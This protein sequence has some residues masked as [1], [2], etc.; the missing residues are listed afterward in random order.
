[1][2][3]IDAIL[4]RRSI[5]RFTEEPVTEEQ[6]ETI[7]RA[8]MYAPSAHNTRT[9]RFLSITDKEKLEELSG[10]ARYWRPLHRATAAI[11][12]LADTTD[13]TPEREEFLIDNSVAATQNMLL[14]AHALG[15]GAVWLNLCQVRD[16]YAPVMECLK[17]PEHIR[18][19]AMI[20]LGHP[21][22]DPPEQPDRFEPEKWHKEVW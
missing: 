15:L 9:W 10:L 21:A 2:D 13:V 1:M 4:T 22:G 11:A 6:L 7:I 8:G 5:R 16:H 19:I 20:A 18:G 14:A 12:V 3:T 17:L